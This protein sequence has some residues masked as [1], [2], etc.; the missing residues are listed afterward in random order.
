MGP[1]ITKQ[2]QTNLLP[3][4]VL[5]LLVPFIRIAATELILIRTLMA[6]GSLL[7]VIESPFDIDDLSIDDAR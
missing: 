4:R 2:K 5:S 3:A 1:R 7:P 6:A